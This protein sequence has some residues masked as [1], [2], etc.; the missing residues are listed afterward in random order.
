MY[1][2][3]SSSLRALN[4]LGVMLLAVGRVDDAERAL[5]EVV[6]RGGARDNVSNASIELMHCASYRRDRMAFERRR[7]EC[8]SRRKEM[9]PNILADF[10][11]KA[12]IGSARFGNFRKAQ[13]QLSAALNIAAESGLNELVFR[14]RS[15]ERRVGKE[16]RSR[17]SPYH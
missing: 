10:H 17:W 8:E 15:E 16:C 11:L 6:R 3:E 14:I 5:T 2:D 7:V 12:G 1:E 4:D 13:V 9:P